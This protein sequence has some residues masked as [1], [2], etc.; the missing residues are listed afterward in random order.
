MWTRRTFLSVAGAAFVSGLSARSA[1]ALNEGDLVFAVAGKTKSG[2]FAAALVNEHGEVIAQSALPDRGHGVTRC[3]V[4][5]RIVVFARRPGTFAVVLDRG[6]QGV[7]TF[8]TPEGR[9]F[10]GHG[11]FSPD[12]KQLFATENDFAAARGIIGIYDAGDNFR[13]IGEF[14]SGGTG[15]H[16]VMISR[17]GRYLCVANGGIETHP[18]FGRAKLNLATMKPNLAWL[19]RA[20]GDLV[21]VHDLPPELHQLSLRHMALGTGA[22]I[23]VGGQYQG[24]R[25]DNPPV[26]ASA[27]PDEELKLMRL[28]ETYNAA[29]AAYVGSLSASPDGRQI[30]AT[31]PVGGAGVIFD[32]ES[33]TAS[34]LDASN[35]SAV[36]W[37]ETGFAFAT[38]H[39]E[40]IATDRT[41]SEPGFYYDQHMVTL[42]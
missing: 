9:H 14:Y 10:Y 27:S 15:P 13:R 16:D 24:E 1:D 19:D 18:D 31:S 36:A 4:T 41:R 32:T 2:A 8:A 22:Q 37:R 6:G 11:A 7:A 3:A 42:G 12:G 34:M 21:G 17:D 5:G 40:F 30:V 25:G 38:G 35:I 23:W 26:L 29:L 33:D 39:G 28:P 20:T